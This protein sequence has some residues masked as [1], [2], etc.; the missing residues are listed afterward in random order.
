M[1][2][3]L[4]L[5]RLHLFFFHCERS[6]LQGPI[7]CQDFDHSS[8]IL[9]LNP[10]QS[11]RADNTYRKKINVLHLFFGCSQFIEIDYL[12]SATMKLCV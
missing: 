4:Y 11:Y 6:E 7:L 8:R 3:S 10:S 5:K 9:N 12:N 2:G 1:L